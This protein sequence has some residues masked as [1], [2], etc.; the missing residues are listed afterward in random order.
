MTKSHKNIETKYKRLSKY[1]EINIKNNCNDV[2][3]NDNVNHF[4]KYMANINE[5]DIAKNYN[6]INNNLNDMIKKKNRTINSQNSPENSYIDSEEIP[7]L[8]RK[9]Y[10][11]KDKGGEY[12]ITEY[13]SFYFTEKNIEDGGK[14]NLFDFETEI[15]TFKH[16]NATKNGKNKEEFIIQGNKII[17]NLNKEETQKIIFR[18]MCNLCNLF[19]NFKK[20]D[21]T[22]KE[23]IRKSEIIANKKTFNSKKRKREEEHG[24]FE[25]L[26]NALRNIKNK[27]YFNYN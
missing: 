14:N 19:L 6:I 22:H 20:F 11:N 13:N 16:E 21:F 8:S 18:E 10:Y 24:N 9:S 27:G 2:E 15:F 26:R 5:N 1:S 4:H 3:T 7:N 25:D 12:S 23:I 17:S